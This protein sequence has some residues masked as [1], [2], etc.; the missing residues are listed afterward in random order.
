MQKNYV[1]KLQK[2]SLN[3]QYHK[4]IIALFRQFE[5]K[6]MILTKKIKIITLN[7]RFIISL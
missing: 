5:K 4:R 2:I 1:F 7:L 3:A 6:I